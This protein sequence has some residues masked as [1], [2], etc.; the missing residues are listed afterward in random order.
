MTSNK[1]ANKHFMNASNLRAQG[2]Q[3]QA[4]K[5]LY[6]ALAIDPHFTP[7]KKAVSDILYALEQSHIKHAAIYLTDAKYDQAIAEYEEILRLSPDSWKAHKN[8]ALTYEKMNL[9]GRAIIEIKKALTIAPH[10]CGLHLTLSQFCDI[11]ENFDMA[12][13]SYDKALEL[14]PN[15]TVILKHKHLTQKLQVYL[16]GENTAKDPFLLVDVGNLFLEKDMP[17]K[18]VK[19]FKKAHVITKKN[20]EIVCSLAHAYYKLKDF[21]NAITHYKAAAKISPATVPLDELF[22]NL[23]LSYSGANNYPEAIIALKECIEN[24]ENG[25]PAARARAHISILNNYLNR[26]SP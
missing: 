9:M 8:L 11:Q 5:E 2:E 18:A 4:L 14:N 13:E 23:G 21:E 12:I 22:Y 24:N 6:Q 10:L 20:Q 7:A 1:E 3:E 25:K 26:L 15:D 17:K 16:A 19:Y